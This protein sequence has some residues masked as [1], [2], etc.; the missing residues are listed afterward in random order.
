[1]ASSPGAGDG[2]TSTDHRLRRFFDSWSRVYDA[3]APQALTYGPVHDAVLGELAQGPPPAAILD[4]GCGTGILAARL[5]GAYPTAEVVGADLSPGML[6]KA[7][8]RSNTVCWIEADAQH[9]PLDSDRFDAV[10][11]TE[12]F[13]WYPDQEAALAE[14][15]RVLRPGGVL[16]LAFV[17]PATQGTA[18][19]ANSLAGAA[20]RPMRWMTTESL[21][22][23]L[24]D[25]GF[26]TDHRIRIK[27]MPPAIL[28]PTIL[29]VARG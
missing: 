12:S 11:C 15:H 23:C 18:R 25:G 9:L 8:E 27:R 29:T 14:F 1:M 24:R 21:E 19:V 3:R 26:E 22:A 13:H 28:F 17:N 10:C 16:Y 2:P 5:A 6:A 20:R 4:V 7:R